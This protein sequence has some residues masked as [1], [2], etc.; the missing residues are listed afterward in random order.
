MTKKIILDLDTGVDDGTSAI[1]PGRQSAAGRSSRA[2]SAKDQK[3]ASS[4]PS[5]R[6]ATTCSASVKGWLLASPT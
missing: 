2:A 1:D 3:N 5:S 4:P 6:S